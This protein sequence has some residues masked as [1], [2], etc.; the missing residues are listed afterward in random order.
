VTVTLTTNEAVTTPAGWTAVGS[1]GKTFTKVYSDNGK[2]TVNVTDLAGNTSTLKY[3]VKR[4]DH[5]APTIDGITDGQTYS[6]TVSYTVTDQNLDPNG[7]TLDGNKVALTYTG[8]NWIWD[9]PEVTGDGEHAIVATDKAGNS[10]TVSFTIDSTGPLVSDSFNVSMSTGDKKTLTPNVS[11]ETGPVTY[12]WSV[13]KPQLLTNP[14]DS[15]SD[16]TLQIGPAP[17]GTYTVTLVVTDEYGN[18]TTKTYDVTIS[19]HANI[20]STTANANNLNSVAGVQGTAGNP[21]GGN[22]GGQVLGAPTDTPSNDA[23]DTHGV[24]GASTQNI[25]DPTITVQNVVA[26]NKAFLGLG[27]WWAAILG[28]LLLFVAVL[29]SSKSRKSHNA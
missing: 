18:K 22:P 21:Q 2:F 29:R 15:L 19:T 27:W 16:T 13:S 7:V 5:T 20:H 24:K 14:H 23:D 10:T 26:T 12:A 6:S 8:S 28:G 25:T 4:I 3:E 11:G 9:A 17:K 1:D